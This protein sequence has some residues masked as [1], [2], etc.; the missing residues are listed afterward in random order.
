M[1]HI[2]FD[3]CGRVANVASEVKRQALKALSV[4]HFKFITVE[5]DFQVDLKS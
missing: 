1:A 5:V 4:D 2:Y 3:K